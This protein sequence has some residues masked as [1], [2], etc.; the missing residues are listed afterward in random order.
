MTIKRY[1]LIIGGG[2][3]M[4]ERADGLYVLHGEHAARIAELVKERD[5]WKAAYGHKDVLLREVVTDRTAANARVAE[6][7]H[8]GNADLVAMRA[9]R[10]VWRDRAQAAEEALSAANARVAE[11]EAD[12]QE[13]IDDAEAYLKT[14]GFNAAPPARIAAVDMPTRTDHERAVVEA[15]S[16]LVRQQDTGE[17]INRDFYDAFDALRR[18]EFARREAEK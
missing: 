16:E 7:E 11:L 3:H 13:W 14:C 17:G 2:Y 15:A 5:D 4:T 8:W 6:L 18:A 12:E 10:N 9:K 1:D